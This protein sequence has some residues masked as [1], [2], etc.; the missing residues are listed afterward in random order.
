MLTKQMFGYIIKIEK[1]KTLNGNAKEMNYLKNNAIALVGR[2]Y[3]FMVTINIMRVITYIIM[4]T[5][6]IS[7]HLLFKEMMAYRPAFTLFLFLPLT[8]DCSGT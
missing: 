8:P 5:Y 6:S 7:Y 1:G 4:Y 2:R 3:F